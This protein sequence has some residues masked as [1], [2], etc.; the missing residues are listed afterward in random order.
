MSLLFFILSIQ[1]FIVIL[2]VSGVVNSNYN[3]LLNGQLFFILNDWGL[4]LYTL[5]CLILINIQT[6]IAVDTIPAAH[7]SR[8]DSLALLIKRIWFFV[9]CDTVWGLRDRGLAVNVVSNLEN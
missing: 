6:A 4:I 9:S 7:P 2:I 3:E 5:H 1:K 8:F